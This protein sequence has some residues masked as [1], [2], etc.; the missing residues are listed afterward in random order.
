MIY[1]KIFLYLAWF[2]SFGYVSG[3]IIDGITKE[4]LFSI[5]G[6]GSKEFCVEAFKEEIL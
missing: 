2:F 5:N 4:E 6:W 1:M 3:R